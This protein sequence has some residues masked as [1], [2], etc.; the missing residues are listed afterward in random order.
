MVHSTQSRSGLENS[1]TTWASVSPNV[2]GAFVALLGSKLTNIGAGDA[3]IVAIVPLPDVLGDLDVG[4]A[5]QTIVRGVTVRVPGKSSVDPK[6]EKFKGALG[7]L[8]GRH[9]AEGS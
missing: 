3:F 8:T 7:T 5:G 2:P 9:I 1:L 6:I 4:G